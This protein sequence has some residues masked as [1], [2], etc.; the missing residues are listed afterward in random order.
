[1]ERVR[2][3]ERD[4]GREKINRLGESNNPPW[5]PTKENP[6]V[7]ARQQHTIPQRGN[8]ST[9]NLLSHVVVTYIHTESLQ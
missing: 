6:H 2:K 4:R 9:P 5:L 1:M 7:Q 3:A 8:H